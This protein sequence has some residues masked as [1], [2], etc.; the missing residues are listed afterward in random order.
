[1]TIRVHPWLKLALYA[2]PLAFLWGQLIRQLS[3][4]WNT[5]PQY[6][7][8]WA[9]PFLCAY[10]LWQRLQKA[11]SSGQR[12][13]VSGQ[14]SVVRGQRAEASGQTAEARAK[15]SEVLRKV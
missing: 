14:R 12:S 9:V 2:L 11:E 10:L 3:V 6:A 4:P 13:G 5:N 8:G 7:Y 1:M 15:K